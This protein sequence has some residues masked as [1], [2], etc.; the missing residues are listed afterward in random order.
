MLTSTLPYAIIGGLLIGLSAAL[1]LLLNGRIAGICG[2]LSAAVLPEGNDRLWR[3][4]FLAGLPGGTLLW[5]LASG[6][7][8]PAPTHASPWLVIV[9]GLVVGYGTQMASGCTSGHGVCGIGRLAPRSIVA[10]LLFMGAGAVTV[11]LARQA[12]LLFTA[13]G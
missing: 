3:W 13:G 4:L 1:L 9:A 2:I 5:H 6:A 7:P 10:T 8:V 11:V 12:S